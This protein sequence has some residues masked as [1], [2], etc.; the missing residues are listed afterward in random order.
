MK[1]QFFVVV[2]IQIVIDWIHVFFFGQTKTS[3]KMNE[4]RDKAASVLLNETTLWIM[5]GL[6]GSG[7][8]SSTEL[9]KL[10]EANSV[11]GPALPTK[12]FES[13]AVK[14]NDSHIY[15]TGGQDAEE[16]GG[17]TSRVWIYKPII[18]AG[19]SSWTEGPRMNI[20]R[21]DHGCTVLHYGQT[22]WIVV[23]GGI[24]TAYTSMEILDPNSNKWVQG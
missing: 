15:L 3:I 18:D 22:S 2:M 10:D 9:I 7:P 16:A 19:N 6:T 1:H 8:L 17:Y 4:P 13:C 5:G 12:L 24:G 14:Y 11:N 23:A 21:G 20:H